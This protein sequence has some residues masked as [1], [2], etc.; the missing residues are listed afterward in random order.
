MSYSYDFF[1]GRLLC[2]NCGTRSEADYKTYMQTYIRD[3]TAGEMLGAGTPLALQAD[4]MRD[5][6]Y[7]ALRPH[8]DGP[9]H[10]GHTWSCPHCGAE[11]LWAEIV[12]QDG[13]IQHITEIVLSTSVHR[14]HYIHVDI[15]DVIEANTDL[16]YGEIMDG[17]IAALTRQAVA[18]L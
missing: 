10:N 15:V 6:D 13:H 11:S 16:G 14:L 2:P 18:S 5:R 3:K 12:I 17:D 4:K 1:V 9:I 7:I 8:R